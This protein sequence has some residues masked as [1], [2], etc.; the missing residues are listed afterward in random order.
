[1]KLLRTT[2][3]GYGT[4][5]RMETRKVLTRYVH[6]KPLL[7]I[8]AFYLFPQGHGTW[9]I[10]VSG[11]VWRAWCTP[12][13]EDVIIGHDDFII[14]ADESLPYPTTYTYDEYART[15]C[16]AE[17][18]VLKAD[19]TA[20]E[21]GKMFGLFLF[22][23]D[24]FSVDARPFRDHWYECF[25]FFWWYLLRVSKPEWVA[26]FALERGVCFQ[27]FPHIHLCDTPTKLF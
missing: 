4:L 9:L 7:I 15:K 24:K 16:E 22:V 18:M 1:M 2:M 21:K 8:E 25:G 6:L 14:N 13:P 5:T 17:K 11:T 27:T 10:R 26:L 3:G 20:L 12:A 19:K 23:L